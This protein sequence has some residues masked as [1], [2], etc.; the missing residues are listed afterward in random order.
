[1][2]CAVLT[3]HTSD[4]PTLYEP[5]RRLGM[6]LQVTVYTELRDL[7]VVPALVS[8]FKPDWTL[9]VGAWDGGQMP[10]PRPE[11]LAAV[12]RAAPLVHLCSD[13]ADPPWGRQLDVYSRLGF[14]LQVT[15]DGAR[16]VP[17]VDL[18]ALTPVDP[19]AFG[20]PAPL[21]VRPVGLGTY[22]GWEYGA[23]RALRDGLGADLVT[24][25]KDESLRYRAFVGRCKAI[26][27]HSATGSGARRHVKGRV[28]EAAL[29]GAVLFEDRDSP[30]D[31]WF[32][33][34]VDYVAYDG[35]DGVRRG[36]AWLAADAAG[37]QAMADR[38]RRKVT[39]RH[40]YQV[41]WEAVDRKSV[42]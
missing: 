30:T 11:D 13:A 39:E 4:T 8:G 34:G 35:P 5:L 1:M 10:V 16:G 2:R 15:I 9:F 17:G 7:S 21:A 12:A 36:L 32:D 14:A 42:V 26:L 33:A 28:L 41:F 6:E 3:T 37:A 29:G 25:P 38:L 20:E 24:W 19:D 23:R 22:G 18:V 27:N 31:Q 40:R